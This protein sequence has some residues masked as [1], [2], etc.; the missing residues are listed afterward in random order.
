MAEYDVA[1]IG[2]GPGGYVAAI[3]AAQLG[4]RT[5]L[6]ER[7]AVGGVCLN[8]GCIPT[9]ALLHCADLANLAQRGDQ[10][11]IGY[12]GLTLDFGVAVDRSREIVE[13]MIGGVETL[14]Q[15]H[16]VTVVTAS[17]RLRGGGAIEL[18]PDGETIEAE[19]IILATGARPRALPGVTIDG[20][21]VLTSREALALREAPRSVVVVGGG[22]VGAEFAYLYRSYGAAVTL[23]EALPRL[24][25]EED[26]EISRHLDRA[27]RA[28]GIAVRAGVSVEEVRVE[29]DGVAVAVAVGD[30]REELR[31]DRALIGVGITPNSDG[32]GLE[33]AGVELDGAFV[34]VDDHCRTNVPGLYAIGDLSGRLPLAHV[35]SAQAVAAVETIAGRDPVPLD[36]DSMP[37]AVYC[38]PQVASIG[39]SETAARDRGHEVKV[40]RFPF[41]ANGKAVALGETEGAV[42][43][44]VDGQTQ[45]VLGVH[46]IGSDATELIGEASLGRLLETTP[47]EIAYAVHPH[48]S[49]SEGLKEAALAVTG[50]A[51]HF[52]D[53]RRR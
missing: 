26:E 36:Y 6:I 7:D 18:T 4:L 47:A 43:L 13:R 22:A 23:V 31:A 2:A 8:W 53:R 5:A 25:P 29:Q 3:R 37:R 41:R 1:I 34:R 33:E 21:R 44:V 19:H 49:L 35:A 11:G 39:L 15:Q 46:I 40:G 32:L 20:N 14:L 16:G 38:Q 48:P 42:K 12:D 10:F 9:K 50:E 51:I 52:A 30:T 27:F 28:Q 17:A 24:L 45:E